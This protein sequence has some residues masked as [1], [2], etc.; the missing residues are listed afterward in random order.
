M[1][2][3]YQHRR[4]DTSDIF[5]IG[6]GESIKRAYMDKQ[7]NKLW[8]NIV[9]KTKYSVEIIHY[10]VSWEQAKELEKWLIDFYGRKD[11]GKGELCNLT[12]GGDGVLGKKVSE[13]TR[14]KMSLAWV[15]RVV[16][17]ETKIKIGIASTGR[18][19]SDEVKAKMSEVQKGNKKNLGKKRTDATKLK[20][21]IS[22]KGKGKGRKVVFTEEHR[23]KLSESKKG[24]SHSEESRKKYPNQKKGQFVA[25][26]QGQN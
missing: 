1:A 19:R 11:L 14:K 15:G 13:E 25:M 26:K 5:Y 24:F 21:S 7:R 23:R 12:D 10:G 22:L 3:V 9:K 8:H 16:S 18:K 2:I 20:Q 17:E 6:I 4:L